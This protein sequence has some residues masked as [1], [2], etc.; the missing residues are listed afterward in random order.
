MA[1]P[2]SFAGLSTNLPTDKLI[3]A[4][5]EQESQPLY[6]M[7]DR[8]ALGTRKVSTLRSIN[9]G[10]L[11][12][13]TSLGNLANTSFQARSVSSSDSAGTYVSAT[14]SGA[15]TGTY[16][17]RVSQLATKAQLTQLNGLATADST[18]VGGGEYALRGMDGTTKTFTL[19]AGDNLQ[20]FR[21]KIN[22]QNLGV[23][24]TIVNTGSATN[25]QKLV[26]SAT[27]TG[28]G[29]DGATQ[30]ALAQTSGTNALGI[31]NATLDGSGNLLPTDGT[32]ANVA[33]KDAAFSI[34]GI[35]ITR[36]SNVVTDAVEG[37][38]LT[39][40]SG[41]QAADSTPTTLTVATDKSAITNAMNEVVTKFNAVLKTI[42]DNSGSG[43][44]LSGEL[45]VR[46][47]LEIQRSSLTGAVSGTGTFGSGAEV[48]LKTNRDGTLS[49][50]ATVFQAALDKDPASVQG[51]F[52]AVSAK[53]S[54][55]VLG[56]TSPGSGELA[57]I[58]QGVDAQNARLSQQISS[59]QSRLD[60]RQE[61]LQAQFA[62]L[63][64]MIGRMQAAGQSL[65]GLA[66]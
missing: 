17:V 65:A 16:D 20:T 27:S 39:L 45:N 35:D 11:A 12:L 37:L 4:I 64:S 29:K 22:S 52:N 13:N 1:S 36:K 56:I 24:A 32:R 14:G 21:D 23:T 5:M 55:S 58:I 49:L 66:R 34:N 63:E 7:Q 48:G 25:P 28:T 46:N 15:A 60:K 53:V 19:E 57:K 40:K 42:Q 30:F 51:I 59:T 54:T 2:I 33:A 44:P 6:R 61:A 38:T 9:S 50:D 26:L 8:Q 3:S 43:K 47:L 10:M 31:A 62:S 18:A 41:G